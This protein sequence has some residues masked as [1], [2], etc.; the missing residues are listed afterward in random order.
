MT[1]AAILEYFAQRE[2]EQPAPPIR[3][4]TRRRVDVASAMVWLVTGAV[5]FG[6]LMAV[7]KVWRG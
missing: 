4:Y 3:V 5:L 6:L 1:R 2:A 7:V